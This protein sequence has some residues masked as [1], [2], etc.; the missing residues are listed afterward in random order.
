MKGGQDMR[1]FMD[2]KANDQLT[3]DEI[4]RFKRDLL[5]IDNILSNHFFDGKLWFTNGEITSVTCLEEYLS[6]ISSCLIDD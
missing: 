5:I 6:E 3:K 1:H 4:N 2:G